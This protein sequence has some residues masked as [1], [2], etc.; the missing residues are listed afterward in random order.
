V[1]ANPGGDGKC[2]HV[3]WCSGELAVILLHVN[4]F[5]YIHISTHTSMYTCVYGCANAHAHIYT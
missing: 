5:I 1:E 2:N 3:H 4:I